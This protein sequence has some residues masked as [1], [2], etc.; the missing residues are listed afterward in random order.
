MADHGEEA[1][2]DALGTLWVRV[3]KI[4]HSLPS[5]KI[6]QTYN[7]CKHTGISTGL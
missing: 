1:E 7:Q 4:R 6:R 3:N 5:G 2:L